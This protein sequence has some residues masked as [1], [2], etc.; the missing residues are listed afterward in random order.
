MT[1]SLEKSE[2]LRRYRQAFIDVGCTEALADDCVGASPF[3]EVSECFEDDPEGA[4]QME[5]SYWDE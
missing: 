4:A 2:W 1:Q 5:M 3:E